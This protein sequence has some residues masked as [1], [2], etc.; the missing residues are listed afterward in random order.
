MQQSS[1]P[2]QPQI[3]VV[4][5]AY[6]SRHDLY[7]NGFVHR[8]VKRYIE[9]GLSVQVFYHHEPVE[10]TYS[11]NF[12]GVKVQV[13]NSCALGKFVSE[14][15]FDVFLV[16]FAEP[17]R[18]NPLLEICPSVPIIIWIH[19]FEA[20]AWHRRWFN[21]IDHNQSLKEALL[22]RD[23]YYQDQ[24]AFLRQLV[25]SPSDHLFVNVSNWFQKMVVEPD[26]GTQF[27]NSVVIPNVV[28]EDHFP[29]AFKD[30]EKRKHILSVRPYAS[31]KYA[32]DQTVDCILELSKRP[33]FEDLSFTICG[34][35]RLWTSTVAPLK[36]FPN[37]TLKNRFFDQGEIARLHSK[38]G[39]FL[40]PTRFDSQG[41]SMC[42]AMSSGLVPVSTKI[43]AIPEFVN[44]N[45][46]GL[47]AQPESPQSLADLVE[48]LYFDSDEFQRLSTSAARKVREKCSTEA[49]VLKEIDLIERVITAND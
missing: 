25:D 19:G 49:T 42:E 15:P 28:D 29:Y 33:F 37:V 20:E 6:P 27:R 48:E 39:V 40:C 26:L 44:P 1:K 18:V 17:E 38:H 31:H 46:S 22:K 4:C 32:N 21:Y 13:G 23:G 7:R 5:N 12:D 43:A 16:H 9:E 41:V 2:S 14:N 45:E 11:Y 47:L 34:K 35:G 36:Q 24:N 8:R 30:A 3:L 10:N